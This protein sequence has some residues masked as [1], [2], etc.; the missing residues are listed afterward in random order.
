MYYGTG[1]NEL[2]GPAHGDVSTGCTDYQFPA[3]ERPTSI[4]LYNAGGTAAE[5]LLGLK[6]VF[7]STSFSGGPVD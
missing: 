4:N 2:A 7:P 5:K 3:N 6:I 1:A